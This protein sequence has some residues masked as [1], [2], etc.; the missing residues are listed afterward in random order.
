MFRTGFA[1]LASI[2]A[3]VPITSSPAIATTHAADLV[4][5]APALMA[6]SASAN[7]GIINFCKG[8]IVNFPTEHLGNCIA[9]QST[10]A[11]GADGGAVANVCLFVDNVAPDF[12]DQ[13]YRTIGDCVADNASFGG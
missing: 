11:R 1:L 8:D 3:I 5:V 6:T 7:Q 9:V 2:S 10:S 12:F 4:T 13:F